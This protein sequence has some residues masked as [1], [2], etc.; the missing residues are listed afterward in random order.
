[1]SKEHRQFNVNKYDWMAQDMGTYNE[2]IMLEFYAS[3]ASTL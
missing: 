1:M 3:Y 2:E